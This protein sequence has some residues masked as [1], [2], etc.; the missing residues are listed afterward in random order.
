MQRELRCPGYVRYVDDALLFGDDR[1]RMWSWLES[2]TA[3]LARFR[4]TIHPNAQPHAT[5]GGFPF[6]GFMVYPDYRRVK[7]RKVVAY[8]RRIRQSVI[9]GTDVAEVV[10][11]LQGWLNHVRY[12]DTWHL[13]ESLLA[14]VPP[15]LGG[16]F[17]ERTVDD[18][19]ADV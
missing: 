8:Y 6:L 16:R 11:S 14:Q 9:Q 13:R 5:C 7:R 12:A 3:R 19:Y 4:L 10:A 15:I 17:A 1:G 2:L 18:L